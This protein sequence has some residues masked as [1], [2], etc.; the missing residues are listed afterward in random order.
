MQASPRCICSPV[1]PAGLDRGN[2]PPVHGTKIAWRSSGQRQGAYCRLNSVRADYEIIVS[3]RAIGEP[4]RDTTIVLYYGYDRCAESAAK[5]GDTRQQ[6]ALQ[7]GPFNPDARTGVAPQRLEIGF[8]QQV[9]LLVTK[10]PSA[11]NRACIFDAR[12]ET[13]REQHAHT[14]GV[15]QKPR[16]Q[17]MPSLLSLDEFGR[18]TLPMKG[19]GR[20]E[21]GYPSADDQDRLDALPYSLRRGELA[22][23]YASRKRLA[24]STS[25]NL[26]PGG[27]VTWTN[28]KSCDNTGAA[29]PP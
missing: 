17:S 3:G 9:P 7:L 25:R 20:G 1:R 24:A 27:T 2:A 4:D 26:G 5:I 16:S 8:R 12:R 11:N 23:H 14:V 18:E 28:V 22:R 15:D 13:E 10:L 29:R 19:C 6:R 21:T